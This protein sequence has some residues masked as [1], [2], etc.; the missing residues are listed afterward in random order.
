MSR[1]SLFDEDEVKDTQGNMDEL[2]GLCSGVFSETSEQGSQKKGV[3]RK[4]SLDEME[5]EDSIE[6][7]SDDE[8]VE[9]DKVPYLP[10]ISG[11]LNSLP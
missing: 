10:K 11:H 1:K 3:K 5:D 4:V 2:M 6:A 9:D 7:F 8:Q